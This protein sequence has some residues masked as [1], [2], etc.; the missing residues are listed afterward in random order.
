MHKRWLIA[1]ALLAVGALLAACSGGSPTSTG[2]S[3]EK[4]TITYG[5]WAGTQTPAMKEIAAAFTEENPNITVKVEERPWPEYWSTLQTGAAGGTAPDAFWM[6]AQNIQPYAAGDQLLD[7]SDAIDSEGVDLAKYP[8]AV[9][10]LYDQGD[11]KIYGLPKDVDTNAVWFNK[12][13][14]DKAGVAYPSA[15]WTWADFRETAKKLTDPAAGVWGTAAPIDYQ[16]GYYNTIFQAGGQVIS[17]DGKTALIDTPEA[18]AGIT[19]WTDL[20]ADGSSPTLQQLS[21]T[22]A[23]TMFEQGKI[24]M[25]MSGAY[26]ALKLYDNK[27]IQ[28]NVDIAPLPVGEERATVTSGI[29]NVGYAGTKHPD[30]VKKFLIFASGEQAAEIQAKSGAVLPAYAGTEKTW[31]AA[32]PEFT[33][34]QVFIDAKEYSVP[35]PVQG[36]AAEWQGEQTKYLTDAWN[37]TATVEDATKQYADAIDK[38]LAE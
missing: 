17:D 31:M 24:G 10:D 14:F 21:D 5:V 9:L 15:D 16:G 36:N 7:I 1:P 26:W 8:K 35:L 34:L 25:Y 37:G 18:Q 4:V 11:G 27:E 28:P 30:A 2:A 22:E 32:M 29:S 38:V 19:F 6:L 20:Q 12:A 13:I 3:D 23:E 33:N